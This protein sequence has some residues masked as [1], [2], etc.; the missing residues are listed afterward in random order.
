[1]ESAAKQIE[2][3]CHSA[4][5]TG[6][7]FPVARTFATTEA[8]RLLRG[9]V[10]LP[11]ATCEHRR[12]LALMLF[13]ADRFDDSIELI[14]RF[15]LAEDFQ[16]AFVLGRAYLSRETPT[17]ETVAQ[18]A[19]DH[20]IAL[21]RTPHERAAGL[22]ESGKAL[23]RLGK[24]EQAQHALLQ[25]LAAN[26]YNFNAFKRL[27]ALALK[28]GNAQVALD[29]TDTLLDRKII[30][31]ALLGARTLAYASL[32]RMTE[33]RDTLG[34]DRFFHDRIVSAPPGW[35]TLEDFNLALAAELTT[36]PGLTFERY[37]TAS[38]GTWR[39]DKPLLKRSRV[40][41][42]LQELIKR[43]VEAY[44]LSLPGEAHPYCESRPRRAKLRYWSVITNADGYEDWHMHP[45]GWLSGVYY[46]QIPSAV[47]AGTGPEGCIEF[48]LT[49]ALA[50]EETA[51]T[52]GSRLVR[53]AP[54][55]LLLFP[56]HSFH[57]TYPHRSTQNR[58]CVSFDIA[59]PDEAAN[60]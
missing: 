59:P 33:A 32:G 31:A 34:H 30:H 19:F 11:S 53:P 2:R 57:R 43:E 6:L 1:M 17:A 51:K 12:Q 35:Q 41:P 58:I 21:A 9:V 16:T 37:G 56:S 22:A 3:T 23:A 10:A 47:E 49:P 20:A 54:G 13:E 24:F 29:H 5:P 26:P 8:L 40:I 36:H 28:S 48:G 25:G 18:S 52:F 60:I 46:V 55:R 38:V 45:G 4:K 50:A 15:Q 14:E 27:T 7:E 44:I 42:H 39:I